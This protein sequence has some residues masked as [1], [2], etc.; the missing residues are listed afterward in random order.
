MQ[1][2]YC[3]IVLV[4]LWYQQY[5]L[6]VY[7][8]FCVM[9]QCFF[10]WLAIIAHLLVLDYYCACQHTHYGQQGVCAKC[11]VNM[12]YISMLVV[13]SYYGLTTIVCASMFTMDGK[14]CVPSVM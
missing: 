2:N 1:W 13:E 11:D 8:M 3:D 9:G 10:V 6:L 5:H 12:A 4:L 7:A 14:V